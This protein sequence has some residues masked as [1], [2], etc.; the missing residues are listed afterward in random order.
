MRVDGR[1]VESPLDDASDDR[2]QLAHRRHARVV[3][4]QPRELLLRL[5]VEERQPDGSQ[6]K[7]GRDESVASESEAVKLLKSRRPFGPKL[8][9]VIGTYCPFLDQL[10]LLRETPNGA[11]VRLFMEAPIRPLSSHI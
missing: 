2:R 7:D 10:W 1:R 5:V 3:R 6:L 8:G 11:L 9:P 4:V